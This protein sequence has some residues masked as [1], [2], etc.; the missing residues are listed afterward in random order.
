MV[1][2]LEAVLKYGG[3]ELYQQHGLAVLVARGWPKNLQT[4]KA[5]TQ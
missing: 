1:V 4:L 2:L 3:V 5:I